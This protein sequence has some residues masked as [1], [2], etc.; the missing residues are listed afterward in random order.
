MVSIKNLYWQIRYDL[1]R[2]VWLWKYK[3]EKENGSIILMY[4]HV[5][6]IPVAVDS[7]C[8][9][10]ISEFKKS[11][12][13]IKD[14]GYSFVHAD[15]FFNDLKNNRVRKCV[16]MTFDDVPDDFYYNAYPILKDNEIPFMLFI[17]INY[18]GKE[19]FLDA[20]KIVEL[21]NDPLCTIG[22][23]T[24]THPLLRQVNNSY[25]EI[26]KSKD[27]LEHLL[28][29]S[30]DYFAYPYGRQSAVSRRVMREVEKAGFKCAF[31]TIQVPISDCSIKH[32]Y[33]LPRMVYK[34]GRLEKYNKY[35][36]FYLELLL[37]KI[38]K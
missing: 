33:Y 25:E 37:K 27:Y 36:F 11:I 31:G 16:L 22:A 19:G 3:K 28:C 24:L 21:N 30:V 26:R 32:V 8:K 9:C 29:K 10:T 14:Q 23:H 20:S 38:I 5:T 17:T 2:N 13:D 4:H 18:I 12:R 7:S 34:G 35:H 6:D 1:L 15:V